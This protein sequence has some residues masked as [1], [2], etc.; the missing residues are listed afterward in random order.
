LPT[1]VKWIGTSCNAKLVELDE[2]VENIALKEMDKP[3][4][5]Y[6]G[7]VSVGDPCMEIPEL[8][9]TVCISNYALSAACVC[10]KL[11]SAFESEWGVQ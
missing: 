1:N 6:I 11:T 10:S 8:D 9:D 2:Y 4:V 3:V 7:A 5:F